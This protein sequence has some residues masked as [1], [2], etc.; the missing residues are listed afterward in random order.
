MS[1]PFIPVARSTGLVLALSCLACASDPKAGGPGTYRGV[2]VGI[3]EV[4]TLEVTVGEAT[5]GP[6]PAS[7]TMTF[8]AR[9]VAL[10]GTLDRSKVSLSLASADGYQ[11]T[12]QSRKEYVLG[13]FIAAKDSGSFALFLVPAG[14]PPVQL[15]CGSL[16]LTST[17]DAPPLPFGVTAMATGAAICVAPAFTLLGSLD[18]TKILSCSS[19]GAAFDGQVNADA[20]G[21]WGTGEGYGTW[22]LQPCGDG[23]PDGGVNSESDGGMD[24]SPPEAGADGTIDGGLDSPIDRAADSPINGT[25]SQMLSTADAEA[26]D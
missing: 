17:A 23:S 21:I 19:N 6:L 22:T 25:D 9:T 13:S 20:G 16:N 3:G 24:S 10:T 26:V 15:F 11:L 8:R 7:G 14:G 18:S 12:G 2:I 1:F 4:G 5:S